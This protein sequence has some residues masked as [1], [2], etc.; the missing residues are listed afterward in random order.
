MN[1]KIILVAVVIML[2]VGYY[3]VQN[4]QLTAPVAPPVSQVDA[5]S[6]DD[7]NI[8]PV[9]HASFAMQFDD[10]LLFNDPAAEYE[11]FLALGTPDI[12]LVSD[13]HGDHLSVEMLN[14]LI[15]EETTI[16]A[17]EVVDNELNQSLLM[18]T[19]VLA[20][21]QTLLVND[22]VIEAMPMYNL[23]E[24]GIE[25]R[26]EKGQGNGYL[27][28]YKGLRVYIA[29]DTA[30]IPELLALEDIDVAFIPMNLPY[31]M[32]VADAAAAVAQFAPATVY[33]YHY[34]TPDGF[35]DVGEFKT[36]VETANPNVEVVLLDWYDGMA[37]LEGSD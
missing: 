9:S 13:V 20:N 7:L 32:S 36:L 22:I 24:Q 31:T 35:S 10:T 34:R 2:G 30:A 11:Q 18:Y 8:T 19:Q 33:P 26:H 25:I 21:G 15:G 3:V 1:K 5:F 4:Y 6:V 29:G 14:G 23:P 28:E 27:L 17:P 12:I 16:I 37:P